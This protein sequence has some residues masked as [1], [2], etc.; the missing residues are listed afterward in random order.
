M[1]SP[2]PKRGYSTGESTM[3][4]PAH[5]VPLGDLPD[6]EGKVELLEE[7]WEEPVLSEVVARP[8]LKEKDLHTTQI[9]HVPCGRAFRR[10]QLSSEKAVMVCDNCFLRVHVP[11]VM[12]IIEEFLDF[13]NKK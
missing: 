7:S 12:E 6:G 10:I 11:V 9:Y 5:I 1:A 8:I 4:A 3:G 2:L 13:I